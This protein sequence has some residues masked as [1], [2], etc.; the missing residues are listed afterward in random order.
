MYICVSLAT[1][2]LIFEI[3]YP[4]KASSW[5]FREKRINLNPKKHKQWKHKVLF[6]YFL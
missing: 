5:R 2:K 6:V 3:Q 4:E 1:H